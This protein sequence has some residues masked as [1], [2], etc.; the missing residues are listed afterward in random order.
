MNVAMKLSHAYVIARD[1][2]SI[3]AKLWRRHTDIVL[4]QYAAG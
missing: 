2:L 3:C 1:Y 4:E